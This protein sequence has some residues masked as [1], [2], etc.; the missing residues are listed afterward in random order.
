LTGYHQDYIGQLARS[1]K[2]MS[3]QVGNRWYVDKS[4]LVAHQEEKNALLAAVQTQSV[5]ITDTNTHTSKMPQESHAT[6]DSLLVYTQDTADLLPVLA[7]K[8]YSRDGGYVFDDSTY[9]QEHAVPIRIIGDRRGRVI[10]DNSIIKQDTKKNT[11]RKTVVIP[12]QTMYRGVYP[13]LVLTVIVVLSV[14]MVSLKQNAR[15]TMSTTFSSLM[16]QTYDLTLVANATLAITSLLDRIEQALS[17]E[18]VY[19]KTK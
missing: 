4:A 11:H 14:G 10:T 1:G 16:N 9:E 2:I 19:Q 15:Y 12:V 13:V 6:D 18:L 7:V 5:G 17:T 3:R 8:K